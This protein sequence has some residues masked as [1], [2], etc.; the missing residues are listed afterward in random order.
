M[1]RTI[2]LLS[3]KRPGVQVPVAVKQNESA[4]ELLE[5]LGLE[6]YRL[7]RADDF[8]ELDD[9]EHF[10][11]NVSDG[12]Q[13]LVCPPARGLRRRDED[14]PSLPTVFSDFGFVHLQRGE[15]E[16][17][18]VGMRS[19]IRFHG[20]EDV[21]PQRNWRVEEKYVVEPQRRNAAFDPE[22]LKF[23]AIL[24]VIGMLGSSMG[25]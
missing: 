7:V 3:T 14:L 1:V 10:W 18:G 2:R 13:F 9:D 12:A 6:G 24:F 11:R 21:M 4:G 25:C 22:F 15:D 8:T 17:L 19:V 20:E 23:L 16:F 5:R